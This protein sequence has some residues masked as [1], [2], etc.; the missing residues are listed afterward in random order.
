MSLRCL[1][2]LA[3]SWSSVAAAQS[4]PD[5]IN[6]RVG[7]R[8]WVAVGAR[9]EPSSASETERIEVHLRFVEAA[10]RGAGGDLDPETQGRRL[11]ALDALAAYRE[12]GVFPRRSGDEHEGRRPRFID[13]RG[14][15]CAV[16]A[17]IAR[18]GSPVLAQEIDAAFEYAYVPEIDHPGLVAWAARFGFSLDELAAIQP[19]YSPPPS[20]E[21]ARD[22]LERQQDGLSIRCAREHEFVPSFV[23]RVRGDSRGHVTWT[24]RGGAFQ[25][26]FARHLPDLS[27]GA[28]DREP[29]RFRD[30][31][32]VELTHPRELLRQ[33]L[34][35]TVAGAHG[36][37]PRPGPLTERGFF[38]VRVNEDGVRV[39]VRTEP[40]HAEVEVCFRRAVLE[41]VG[42]VF[43][44]GRWDLRVRLPG[45]VFQDRITDERLESWGG[46]VGR[47]ISS[48]CH[49]HD[50]PEEVRL[51]LATRI[52][53]P[54]EIEIDHANEA[55]LVCMREGLR[56][57]FRDEH[58]VS[59]R[60]RDGSFQRFFRVDAEAA[61][62]L[63]FEHEPP[64]AR[65]ARIQAEEERMERA[66][67][68]RSPL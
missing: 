45:V 8:S 30:R 38:H 42:R 13:D 66:L 19:A 1:L 46:Y 33:Q 37:R 27:G 10:L 12:A 22:T 9:G 58:A 52:D 67:R 7:D 51:H 31:I 61:A 16:G 63:S 43:E 5:P 6:V 47:R 68:E 18:T 26:C 35:R 20:E 64:R 44:A 60:M 55:Y 62:T 24:A 15:H 40:R 65:E 14:V 53:Q 23:V 25:K 21:V 48:E 49:E 39:G 36:C 50:A 4:H 59:R 11:E 41:Q 28:W 29:Q 3:A 54:L 32:R 56:A 17:M 57:R 2:V 34:V